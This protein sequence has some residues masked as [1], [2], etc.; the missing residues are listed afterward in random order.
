MELKTISAIDYCKFVTD[1]THDSPKP[2]ESGYKLITS[3][4]L[5]RYDIDFDSANYISEEDYKKVIERSYV[6]QWDI[7]FSM[8]GTIGNTYIETNNDIN[9]A[10]KNMGIFQMGRDEIKAKWLY[11]YLQTPKAKAYIEAVSRGTTQGYV[12]LGALRKM[13]IEITDDDNTKKIVSLLWELDEI[14]KENIKINSNLEQQARA[15]FKSW[16]VDYEPFGGVMPSDWQVSTLGEISD[17][18]AGGDKP[19]IAS[20]IETENCRVPIYSNGIT[21]EGLYGYTDKAR[22]FDE[23]V[24]V[25]ARGTI[26]Y[27][28]LRQVPYVPIV[29]LVSLTPKKKLV[30]AKYLYLFLKQLHIAGTGT[31]QQQLTV[32]N[33]KG[34]EILIPTSEIMS[35]F[36]DI[37]TPFYDKILDNKVEIKKLCSLRDTLL[38]K[39]M[40]GE[41]DLS[42]IDI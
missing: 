6:E 12:P 14:I 32:P 29:R 39:L 13:P 30:S 9:Y 19:D 1:G 18:S 10:C 2:K 41:I 38:P 16:F 15:I 36:T 17:M 23:S 11:Y 35:K 34:T 26:G 22:I 4:H 7:L 20:D 24:T 37:I 21:D 28:C 42:N 31:T 40:S 27:V 3:K 8:I 25:S 33:F 5:K